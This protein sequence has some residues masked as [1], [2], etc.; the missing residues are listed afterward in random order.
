MMRGGH[1][2]FTQTKVNIAAD[3]VKNDR[4]IAS[5]TGK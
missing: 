2:K 1:P 4:Q 3:F 5:R